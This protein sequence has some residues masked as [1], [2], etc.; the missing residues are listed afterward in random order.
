MCNSPLNAKRLQKGDALRESVESLM[1]ETESGQVQL[2]PPDSLQVKSSTDSSPTRCELIGSVIPERQDSD[3]TH[4][5][6][7]MARHMSQAEHKHS[8]KRDAQGVRGVW[9]DTSRR[10]L[11]GSHNQSS[12]VVPL[13]TQ[14][15][16]R[17]PTVYG[18]LVV[19][20]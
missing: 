17:V 5:L 6:L 14:A 16:L 2:S 1:R 20:A 8:F 9:A 10:L 19:C 4:N 12:A 13:T 7:A 3:G 11:R 15:V 18:S